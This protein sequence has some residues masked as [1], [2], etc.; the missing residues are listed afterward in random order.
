MHHFVTRAY[1]AGMLAPGESRL[2]VY[3]RNS[4]RVFR[5]IPENLAS[6]RAYYT[7][8]GKDGVGHD[9]FEKFLAAEIEGPGISVLRRLSTGTMQLSWVER[10][11]ATNLI[12]I[13][14]LRV[15]FM[16]DQ[17]LK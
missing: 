10:L 7:V 5:N 14:E 4:D 12:A 13:Q 8:V 6:E 11:H 1:L 17:P 16:R 3:E 2:W 15:P 9:E